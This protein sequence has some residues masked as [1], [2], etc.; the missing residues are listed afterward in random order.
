MCNPTPQPQQD[1][2]RQLQAITHISTIQ[3]R[4]L[5]ADRSSLSNPPLPPHFRSANDRFAWVFYCF[6]HHGSRSSSPH[7]KSTS[8]S[9]YPVC[10][11]TARC[12][13][14]IFASRR[15]TRQRR[16]PAVASACSVGEPKSGRAQRTS[17]PKPPTPS[18][19]KSKVNPTSPSRC[20]AVLSF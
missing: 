9:L 5:C 6:A 12:N 14:T 18:E 8:A 4:S 19:C 15:P 16:A 2:R 1:R 13:L 3:R 10:H 11:L 17:I 7:A 20:S